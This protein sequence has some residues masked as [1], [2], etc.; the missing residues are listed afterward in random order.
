MNQGHAKGQ[1]LVSETRTRMAN[2]Q[3]RGT[4]EMVTMLILLDRMSYTCIGTSQTVNTKVTR[5]NS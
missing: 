2:R 1:H 3:Q 4:Y 5:T